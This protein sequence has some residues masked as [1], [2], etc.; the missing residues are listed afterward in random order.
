MASVL[1]TSQGLLTRAGNRLMAILEENADLLSVEGIRRATAVIEAEAGKLE[2]VL[3]KYSNTS[4]AL[5]EN[6]PS[7]SELSKRIADHSEAAQLL[8]DRAHEA[9]STLMKLQADIDCSTDPREADML[10]TK[11][12]PIPI[13]KCKGDIWEWD[14]FWTSFNHNSCRQAEEALKTSHLLTERFWNIWSHQYLTSL[15]ET[16]KLQIDNKR[17]TTKPPE[18][19]TVVLILEQG[20]IDFM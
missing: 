14:T 20:H 5:D 3:Y 6:T 16:H 1:S 10:E 12:A 15:R 13:R 18:V 8:I 9:L 17:G 19:G 11:L 2:D 7:I 4:D